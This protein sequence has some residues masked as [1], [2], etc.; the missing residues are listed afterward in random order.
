MRPT[1]RSRMSRVN[2]SAPQQIACW[3]ESFSKKMHPSCIFVFARG[4]VRIGKLFDWCTC[5]VSI[6]EPELL[7]FFV[8]AH[9]LKPH[10]QDP[11]VVGFGHGDLERSDPYLLTNGG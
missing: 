9:A 11:A 3:P 1:E 7:F 2:P 6:G 5:G 10:F 4:R 8:F